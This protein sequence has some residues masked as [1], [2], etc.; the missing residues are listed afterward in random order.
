MII[1]TIAKKETVHRVAAYARVSTMAESQNE[2]FE[3]QNSFYIN[4][5]RQNPNRSLVNVYADR[6]IT[7]TSAEKRPGFQQMIRDAEAGKMDLI[8]CKSISRFSRNYEEAQKYTHLLKSLGIE[9]R[10][11]KEGIST[12]DPQTDLILGA[13]MSIAQQES[14]SISDNVR[15]ANQRL[16]EQGI[17]HVGS[18]HLLGY[19]EV[20]GEMVPNKDKWII[21]LIFRRYAAGTGIPDILAELK[22][23]GAKTLRTG[24]DFRCSNISGILRNEVYCGDRNILK[25]PVRNYLTK[26][27]DP[28]VKR[29]S[30]YVRDHHAAI[31]SRQLWDAAQERLRTE[32]IKKASGERPRKDHH[33]YF[34][35]I[36]CASCGQPY[37]RC[38]W[39][40]RH[41]ETVPM[42][43]CSGRYKG[44]CF[45]RIVREDE[46]AEAMSTADKIKVTEFGLVAC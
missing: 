28:T 6:G 37:R 13:M 4:Y 40:N 5:I 16:A 17:R 18:H 10:F 34:N 20:D 36:I 24:G 7:G 9:V 41:G 12:L 19:D 14:K 23:K 29:E 31:V 21:E 42:W 2:S 39:K 8:L 38:T 30:F 11:E 33:P 15:W 46:L 43:K 22:E 32:Q 27:I 45:A 26:K 25:T 35:R 1:R 44:E 3:A